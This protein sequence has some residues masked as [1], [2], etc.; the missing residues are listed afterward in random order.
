MPQDFP[1]NSCSLR[2]TLASGRKGSVT[3]V[4]SAAAVPGRGYV[5][6][7]AAESDSSNPQLKALRKAGR[8]VILLP[9][10]LRDSMD[11]KRSR[12]IADFLAKFSFKIDPDSG[13]VFRLGSS[14][15]N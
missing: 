4:S 2:R 3:L 11:E 7:Y 8:F 15:I 14:M 9:A 1:E 5:F 10:L 13:S 12:H 6:A